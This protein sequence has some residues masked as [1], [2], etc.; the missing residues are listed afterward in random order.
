MTAKMIQGTDLM[1]LRRY[2]HRSPEVQAQLLNQ[3]RAWQQLHHRDSESLKSETTAAKL[4][5]PV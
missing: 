3:V 4:T 2:D 1:L 5:V